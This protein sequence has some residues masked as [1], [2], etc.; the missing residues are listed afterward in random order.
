[1]PHPDNEPG[2]SYDEDDRRRAAALTACAGLP[3][4][5]LERGLVGELYKAIALLAL[6]D[7]MAE[8]IDGDVRHPERWWND[9]VRGTLDGLNRIATGAKPN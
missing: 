1:M 4:E 9:H 7:K 2:K 6:A 8:R 3:T 5:W